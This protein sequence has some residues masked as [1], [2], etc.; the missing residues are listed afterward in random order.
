METRFREC[1]AQLLDYP[2]AC[3]VFRNIEVENPAAAMLDDKE[4]IQDSKCEGWHCEEIR[5]RDDIN[6][7][8]G[9][10]VKC[11]RAFSNP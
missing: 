10:I 3:R 11:G 6:I 4:A 7:Q 1:I 2:C 5:G 8:S 9:K